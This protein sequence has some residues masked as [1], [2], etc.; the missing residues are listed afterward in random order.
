MAAALPENTPARLRQADVTNIILNAVGKVTDFTMNKKIIALVLAA[1]MVV[2]CFAF[3]GCGG[4]GETEDKV[5]DNST[6]EDASTSADET[7]EA[8][9]TV[10]DLDYIKGRGKLVVAITDFAPMNYE[11]KKGNGEWIGFDTEFTK[12]VCEK[13]GVEAEFM[14]ID[15]DNRFAELDTKSVDCLWNGMTINEAALKATSVS[16]PYAKNAQVVVMKADKIADYPD[17]ESMKDLKFV[18]EA[19]SA[20][21]TEAKKI[22]GEQNYISVKSQADTLT[23]VKSGSADACVIDLTMAQSMTGEG[24]SYADLGFKVELSKEEYGISFRKGSDLTAEVNK[25]M[26][27]LK[28]DGTLDKL[29]E[30]Y[31]VVLVK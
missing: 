20:G 12:A 6:S 5:S 25:I 31:N 14:P 24:T 4:N 1:L 21:E 30:K 11:T 28:A 19:G 10:K 3:Y 27:E 22:C 2:M 9:A 8:A 17:V 13:L 18:A 29:A 16:D 23:E 26:A 15:W 7:T